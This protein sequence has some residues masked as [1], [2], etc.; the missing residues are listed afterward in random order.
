ME[1]LTVWI[2]LVT[3][4]QCHSLCS[5][6]LCVYVCVCMCVCVCVCVYKLVVKFRG[7]SSHLKRYQFA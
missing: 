6:I 4:S 1:A 5:S 3:F 2:L 7:S